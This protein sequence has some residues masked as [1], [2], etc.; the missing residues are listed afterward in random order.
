MQHNPHLNRYP[1]CRIVRWSTHAVWGLCMCIAGCINPR[2]PKRGC[3]TVP[4]HMLDH[5]SCH[6]SVVSGLELW[7]ARALLT[8]HSLLFPPQ[9]EHFSFRLILALCFGFRKEAALGCLF[10]PGF[11]G[12]SPFCGFCRYH[13]PWCACR[14]HG[15]DGDRLGTS[16]AYSG[17]LSV[18]GWA[19]LCESGSRCCLC[20]Q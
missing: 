16:F 5:S 9:Q 7:D 4:R 19:L 15:T 12:M 18:H 10:F 14:Q 1:P 17:R 2:V 20:E 13:F 11:V 3:V 8:C 6:C